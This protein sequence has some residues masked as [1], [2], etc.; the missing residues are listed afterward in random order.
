MILNEKLPYYL[1]YICQRKISNKSIGI[2]TVGQNTETELV[3]CPE[4]GVVSGVR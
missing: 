4:L 3:I 1:I 2:K